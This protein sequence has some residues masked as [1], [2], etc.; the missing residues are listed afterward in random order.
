DAKYKLAIVASHAYGLYVDAKAILNMGID[1]LAAPDVQFA[2]E[3]NFRIKLV[4]TAREV[5]DR[6][7]ILYVMPKLIGQD[8]ILYNVENEY[9]G[10]LVK[11]AFADEQFFYGKGAGGHP[12]GSAV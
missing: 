10:V 3:K 12:T 8:N 1:T 9:N 5:D 2:R 4:P 7:V 6:A 11:A